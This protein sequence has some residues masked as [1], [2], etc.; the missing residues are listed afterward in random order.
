MLTA[1]SLLAGAF[2]GAFQ[3]PPQVDE[4]AALS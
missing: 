1:A 4:R 3:P 2:H